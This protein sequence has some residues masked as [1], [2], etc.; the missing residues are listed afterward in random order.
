MSRLIIS[1]KVKF[2]HIFM[3]LTTL[4]KRFY[5]WIEPFV[6]NWNHHKDS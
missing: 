5:C 1:A 2:S 3:N 6:L 4:Y